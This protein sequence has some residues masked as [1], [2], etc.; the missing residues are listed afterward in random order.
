MAE[1][2]TLTCFYGTE[3]EQYTFFWISKVLFTDAGFKQTAG[4]A[5][6]LYGFVLDRMGLSI[7]NS[8]LDVAA[9]MRCMASGP[10]L[11]VLDRELGELPNKRKGYSF[12][13]LAN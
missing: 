5:K 10:H 7:R 12:P 6:I 1:L 8:W 11:L 9:T 2:G 4:V 3:A 13:L